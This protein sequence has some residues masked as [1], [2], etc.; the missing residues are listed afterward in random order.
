MTVSVRNAP[1]L[2]PLSHTRTP[3]RLAAGMAVSFGGVLVVGISESG[4]AACLPYR[5]PDH[6]PTGPLRT[7]D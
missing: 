7:M 4:T 2:F 5:V 3:R 6:E 1:G